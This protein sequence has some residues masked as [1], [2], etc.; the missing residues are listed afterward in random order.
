MMRINPMML[1][2][3]SHH[4][5]AML[6]F[7]LVF[8]GLALVGTYQSWNTSLAVLNLC[9][10]SAVMAMG[11]NLQWGYAGLF[12]AGVMAFTAVGGVTAVLVSHPP[13]VEAWSAGGGNL[14]ASVLALI[15]S[16]ALFRLSGRFFQTGSTGFWLRLAIIL[17]GYFII[18]HFF[19]LAVSAIESVN[20]AQTG[21]LGGL[22]LPILFSWL[23]GGLS[24]A[25]LAWFIGRIALGL[26]SDYLAIA[27]LG[28]SE[29]VISILKNE[30]WLARGVKNVTGLKRP[31]PYEIDLQESETFISWVEWLY[32]SRLAQADNAKAMLNDLV[33]TSSSLFVKCCYSA[34][35]IVTVLVILILCNRAAASPWGRMM[36]AIR[37]NETA[38]QAMGKDIV[39]RHRQ[40][41]I[42]GSA[43]IG[44]AGAMLTT[45]DGQFTPGSYQPL[46]FTFLIWV[47]VIIGGSGNNLGAILGGFIIWFVWIEAEPAA[48]WLMQNI[49]A[50]LDEDSALGQHLIDVAPQMRLFVMGIV[51]LVVMRFS[52]RGILPERTANR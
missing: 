48:G 38:A 13:V 20:P 18:R 37:D 8:L 35:F 31:V 22:G 41:F 51:L 49:A 23:A 34:L 43:I 4:R 36:R 42:L 21:F 30:D 19:G 5:R 27:T 46:R 15:A 24:A 52:P 45:L 16:F 40:V 6:G 47:M 32:A 10:I 25:A 3:D 17:I 9:L 28:I 29:I 12:N 26:R 14:A 11:L 1:L 50:S 33:I 2:E 7:G 39:A 44:I